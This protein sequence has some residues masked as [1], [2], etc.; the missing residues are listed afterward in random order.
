MRI[1]ALSRTTGLP[2]GTVKFY[3][4]TGL[5][6]PGRNTSA[7]QAIY[8]DSHIVRLRLVRSLLEVGRLSLAQIQSA[9]AITATP[10]RTTTEALDA[11]R[12][13]DAPTSPDDAIA[14]AIDLLTEL[15]W[16]VPHDQA[17]LVRLARVIAAYDAVGM[18][19]TAGG[20]WAYASAAQ[21]AARQDVE[22]ISMVT[23]EERVHAALMATHLGDALLG[24]L[25]RLSR[26][27]AAAER[28]SG[29]ERDQDS[30]QLV[31]SGQ[32]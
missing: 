27:Q 20:A 14:P 4:R 11:A 28:E 1:G 31:D 22:V 18:P 19:L 6:H 13:L 21:T 30:G 7:T 5:L 25:R 2:L 26:S 9:I 8:D 17:D 23:D 16:A 15:G 12:E 24:A 3:L 10:A 29:Q 32:R